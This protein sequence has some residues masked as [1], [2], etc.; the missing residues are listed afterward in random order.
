[1]CVSFLTPD[2][3][4]VLI[5]IHLSNQVRRLTGPELSYYS[6]G[7]LLDADD[8]VAAALQRL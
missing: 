8:L 1:M 2:A 3:P 4:R 5:I 7:N 6:N